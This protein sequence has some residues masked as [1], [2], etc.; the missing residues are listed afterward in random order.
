MVD[1]SQLRALR[2]QRGWT[3]QQAAARLRVTQAYLSMLERGRR[4][5]P[6][7]LRNT[8]VRVFSLPAT[9]LP[10]PATACAMPEP[11]IAQAVAALGYPGFRHLAARPTPPRN[12]AW[13][14]AAA[15]Q[16]PRLEARLVEALPWLVREYW[17]LDW[18]WLAREAKLHGFVNQLGYI[19]HL[20]RQLAK[21]ADNRDAAQELCR[22]ETMLEPSRLAHESSFAGGGLSEAERRWLRR[23]RS[24]E[25]RRWNLLTDLSVE[26]LERGL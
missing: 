26:Q 18:E 24:P 6:D 22:V 1:G 5:L 19:V 20:A 15:L 17:N 4:P 10:L 11:E 12:P 21:H 9:A 2:E 13:V 16:S 3:Q 23:H 25:A 8:V 7:R 14:M